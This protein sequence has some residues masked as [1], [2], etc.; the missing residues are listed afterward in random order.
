[1]T[2]HWPDQP[3]PVTVVAPAHQFAAIHGPAGSCGVNSVDVSAHGQWAVS[4]AA[5][6]SLVHWDLATG[7]SKLV[8]LLSFGNINK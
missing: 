1:L 4:G 2:I 5:D 8:L 7:G 6:G 3:A